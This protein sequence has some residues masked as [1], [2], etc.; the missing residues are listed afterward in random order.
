VPPAQAR[1]DRE[2]EANPLDADEAR[3]AR[4][5]IAYRQLDVDQQSVSTARLAF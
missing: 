2:P 5:I 3:I 1:T 4:D